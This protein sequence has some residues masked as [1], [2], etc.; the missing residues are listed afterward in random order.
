[1]LEKQKISMIRIWNYNKSRIHSFRGAKDI[2]IML[3]KK[4][5]FQGEIKKA[6]GVLK[7]SEQYCE[8]IMFTDDDFLIDEIERND[9]INEIKDN[10]EKDED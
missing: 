1:M 2:L 10:E 7:G 8:Y 5:V 4:T 6:P 3:D 9:W